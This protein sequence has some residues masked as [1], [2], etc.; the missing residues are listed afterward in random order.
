MKQ[1]VDEK[2]KIQLFLNKYTNPTAL[3]G[4]AEQAVSGLSKS[5][6]SF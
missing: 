6:G 4:Y 3:T 2:N 1:K 5:A